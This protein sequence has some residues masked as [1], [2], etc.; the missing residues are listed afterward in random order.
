MTEFLKKTF[1]KNQPKAIKMVEE[2]EKQNGANNISKLL[3]MNYA[4]C[5]KYLQ[6]YYGKPEGSFFCKSNFKSR[7]PKI[8]KTEEGLITWHVRNDVNYHL[9]GYW[10][11]I[12]YPWEYQLPENLVYCNLLEYLILT[13]KIY[14][15]SINTSN[16]NTDILDFRLI[17]LIGCFNDFYSKVNSYQ[18]VRGVGF[19][20]IKNNIKE[21][22]LIIKYFIYLQIYELDEIKASYEIDNDW[23][24][25]S[26]SRNWMKER[27]KP[28]FEEIEKY[29]KEVK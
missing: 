14:E 26:V 1:H 10:T 25:Y 4:D 15:Q 23:K 12:K 3:K 17:N 16:L 27:I 19:F 28:L 11:A 9:A 20:T 24:P 18:S 29:K 2:W 7:N 6:D 8:R 13:Y 22:L 5:C 21:Y